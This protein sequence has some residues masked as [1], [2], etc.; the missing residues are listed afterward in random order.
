M[1]KHSCHHHHH[2]HEHHHSHVPNNRKVLWISFIL[3]TL[4]MYVELIG[5]Y[6]SNS[7]ALIADAGHMLTDAF[8]LGLAV[9]ASVL[10]QKKSDRYNTFG[11][12]RSEILAAAFNGILLF[13]IAF[14]IAYEAIERIFLAPEILSKTMLIIAIIGL[15]INI[16][17]AS[18]MWLYGD[19]EDNLNVRAA[20]LH[21]LADMLGSVGAIIAALLVMFFNWHW[22][23]TVAS[24]I[25]SF[26]ILRS[27][28]YVLKQ[29]IQILMQNVP[30]Q[31]NII[32]IRRILLQ[33]DFVISIRNLHVWQLNQDYKILTCHVKVDNIDNRDDYQ[34]KLQSLVTSLNHYH[35]NEIT[36]QLEI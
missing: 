10:S 33:H 8:S 9:L 17:V 35:L 11:Y 16:I 2:H 5:G 13:I 31:V 26:I 21:V 28:F 23:D 29:S 25:V 15:I 22:A 6:I 27:A 34:H 24:V 18:L 19:V 20:F 4:F 30:K 12:G 14:Y 3:I 36:I 32:K 7:L 1:S